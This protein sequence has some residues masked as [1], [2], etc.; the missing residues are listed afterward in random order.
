MPNPWRGFPLWRAVNSNLLNN[1]ET[2]IRFRMSLNRQISEKRKKWDKEAK[3]QRKAQK[4]PFKVT[5]SLLTTGQN[6][7]IIIV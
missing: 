1:E 4:E 7:G 5:H 6:P 2:K 3:E